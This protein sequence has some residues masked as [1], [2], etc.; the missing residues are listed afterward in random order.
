M[1]GCLISVGC[2]AYQ[3]L[4]PLSGA[5]NDARAVYET[6]V[7]SE[8]SMYSKEISK[9]LLSPSRTDFYEE[10]GR[11]SED[12]T[13]DVLT[14]YFAGHGSVDTGQY[15]LHFPSEREGNLILS[16]ISSGEIFT[17]ISRCKFAHINLII[18]ACQT[19]GIIHNLGNIIKPEVMGHSRGVGITI[20]S[21]CSIDEYASEINGNGVL[22]TEL[23]KTLTGEIKVSESDEYVDLYQAGQKIAQQDSLIKLNQSPTVWGFNIYGQ[24][25]LAKNPHYTGELGSFAGRHYIPPASQMGEAMKRHLKPLNEALENYTEIDSKEK[26]LFKLN[27]IRALTSDPLGQEKITLSFKQNVMSE[28]PSDCPMER[29]VFITA[30]FASCIRHSDTDSSLQEINELLRDT[31]RLAEETVGYLLD[32]VEQDENFLSSSNATGLGWIAEYYLSPIRVSM[33]LGYMSEAIRNGQLAPDRFEPLLAKI[34][35]SYGNSLVA[36]S[37]AQAPYLLVFF[38]AL[39]GTSLEPLARECLR[40]YFHT[41]VGAR[42]QVARHNLTG[43]NACL[44]FIERY[45]KENIDYN[46]LA[47]PNMLGSVM[48][49][50]GHVYDLADEFDVMLREMDGSNFYLFLS[51]EILSFSECVVDNG[52]NYQAKCGHDFWTVQEFWDNF[53]Q[54]FQQFIP[55]EG[56][57]DT[58]KSC[59][60]ASSFTVPDRLPLLILH[61]LS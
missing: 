37:D 42:G 30:I 26:F 4:A 11:I 23:L 7:D 32:Q 9:L 5:E 24:S 13:S 35:D 45:Q 12:E 34:F 1:N 2:D 15:Y 18:D 40:R 58:A 22:T 39:H 14:L 55:E 31:S 6:L 53:M 59:I 60:V 28:I 49:L 44:Y 38:K 21:S 36:L 19:N 47:N 51:S 41:L 3:L 48:M 16:A 46:Y 25:A 27:E 54:E 52:F 29:L 33:I 17:A 57:S 56:V 8:Y 50:M 10:L 61:G 20:L 43:R